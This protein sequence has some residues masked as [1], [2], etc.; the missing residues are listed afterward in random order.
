VSA[1]QAPL[2][3][4]IGNMLLRDEGVG[5]RVVSELARGLAEGGPAVPPGT[6]FVDG[7]TLGLELLPMIQDASILVLVDAVN[8]RR[9]PGSAAVFRG[10]AIEGVLAGHVSPH[11][12]GVAD[13][14]AAARLLGVLPEATSLVGIQ[15]ALIEIGLE[16]T[17]AV[18][19]A[20]PVAMAL[21]REE[22]ATW[23]R[24]PLAVA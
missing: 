16:L 18:E 24:A 9:P 3:I 17:A 20:V 6:T 22:L 11:Q 23:S 13:L 14:V 19:E 2:V 4:G 12:V 1:L 10:D 5:V 21:V 8:L 7:G 15:P